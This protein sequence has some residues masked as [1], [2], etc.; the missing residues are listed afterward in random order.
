MSASLMK[1]SFAGV[2]VAP[3]RSSSFSGARVSR[4][5]VSNGGKTVMRATQTLNGRSTIG[6]EDEYVY[7]RGRKV[8]RSQ[9]PAKGKLATASTPKAEAPSSY[10][11]P[12]FTPSAPAKEEDFVYFRGRKVPR[13]QVP[14]KNKLATAAT[15][16]ASGSSS[17]SSSGYSSSPSPVH[18]E[19]VYFRGRKVPRSQLP[20]LGK[21]TY[22]KGSGSTP[23]S[24]PSAN[25]SSAPTASYSSSSQE[26]LVYFRGRKVPR[27]QVPKK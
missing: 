14:N 11:A 27:S 20:A 23:S 26:E 7:F 17:A 18:D 16:K 1:P 9:A 3:A 13:S 4:T 15:P 19:I 22:K 25:Y 6:T 10:S 2:S 8:P 12:S 21:P 5:L 24:T